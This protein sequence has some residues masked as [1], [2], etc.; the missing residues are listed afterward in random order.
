MTKLR[1][2][3]AMGDY[4]RV[5]PLQDG[6]VAIEGVDPTFLLLGPEEMFFR[7]FRGQEFDVSEV[8]F[9]SYLLSHSRGT[10]PYIAIPVF[11]S[12]AFRHTCVYVRK[13]RIGR[14]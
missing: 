11:L 9:S 8:S 4:D 2:S 12:R 10:C 6:R 7:A 1:L 5:R 13:E 14:P 3:V